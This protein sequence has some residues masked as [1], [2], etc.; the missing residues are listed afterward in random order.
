MKKAATRRLERQT[1]AV[2]AAGCFGGVINTSPTAL[3]PSAI[4]ITADGTLFA[5][6]K[7]RS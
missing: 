6:S 4:L 1:S 5:F 7:H 2:A 3:V